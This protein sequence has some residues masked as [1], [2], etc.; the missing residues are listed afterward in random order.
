MNNECGK[1]SLCTNSSKCERVTVPYLG[2]VCPDLDTA[3]QVILDKTGLNKQAF[4]ITAM[5]NEVLRM[6]DELARMGINPDQDSKEACAA[7]RRVMVEV[8]TR[9]KLIDQVM[10]EHKDNQTGALDHE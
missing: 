3:I 10:Q 6:N 2:R 1:V 5:K 8:N 7:Y 4:L 9:M